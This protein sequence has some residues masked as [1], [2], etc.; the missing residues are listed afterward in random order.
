MSIKKALPPEHQMAEADYGLAHGEWAEI[1][2]MVDA[3][4][5]RFWRKRGGIP[6]RHLI[7]DFKKKE[8]N[9]SKDCQ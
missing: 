2:R 9:A 4:Y 5:E 6:D 3:G 7:N 1:K 8:K